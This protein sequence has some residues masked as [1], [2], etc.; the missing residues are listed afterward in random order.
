MYVDK[1]KSIVTIIVYFHIH[2]PNTTTTTIVVVVSLVGRELRS[3]VR[4]NRKESLHLAV[5]PFDQ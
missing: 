5:S 3:T 1:Q 4:E 2:H